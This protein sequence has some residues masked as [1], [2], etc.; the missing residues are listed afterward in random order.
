MRACFALRRECGRVA[1]CHNLLN[2]ARHS[3]LVAGG[4][5]GRV[6]CG[7]PLYGGCVHAFLRRRRC[8]RV[9]SVWRGS[10]SE[11]GEALQDLDGI[12][13]GGL[14]VLVVELDVLT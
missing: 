12:G 1:G 9:S 8:E 10:L 11:I 6:A 5:H 14:D 7:L 13:D 3:N 2:R 4:P